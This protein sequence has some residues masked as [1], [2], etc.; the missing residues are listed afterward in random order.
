MHILIADSLDARA[1]AALEDAGHECTVLP[2]LTA[3]SIPEHVGEHEILIVRST[4]VTAATIDAASNLKLVVRAGAGTNTIDLAAA[5]AAGVLVA[6][7]PGANAAAVAELA[8][9]LMLAIDRR[10]PEGVIELRAGHWDKKGMT[11]GAQGLKGATLGIVGLG[12]IG[13]GVAERAKAFG[14]TILALHRPG[15]S[16]QTQ[17]RIDELGIELRDSLPELAGEVDILTLHIPTGPGT[18]GIVDKQTLTAMR[19]GAVLINTSRA[20]V[21]DSDAL[22]AALDSG[23]LRAGLDVYPDEPGSGTADWTS[24][25][26]THPAVVGTHHVGASTAQ[27]QAAVAEGVVDVIASFVAGQPRNVV[28]P[29]AQPSGAVG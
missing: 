29:E 18:V 19:P 13:L 25:L 3:D 23:N 21:I 6:N 7:V 1:I 20:D 28:N 2:D 27:A 10:I 26:A 12:S 4:K 14:M 9:G 8:L 16:P 22:L 24:A 15:R 17:A 5:T 11:K